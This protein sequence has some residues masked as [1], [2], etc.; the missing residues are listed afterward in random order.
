MVVYKGLGIFVVPIGFLSLLSTE[1]FFERITGDDQYYQQHGWVILVGMLL[2]AALTHEFHRMLLRQK[3]RV[4]IEKETG[5]EIVERPSHSL[6]LIPVKWWPI[7]FIVLGVF[8]A[9]VPPGE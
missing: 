2:A 9:F 4:L 8:F 1:L 7:V 3:G 5:R 6:F